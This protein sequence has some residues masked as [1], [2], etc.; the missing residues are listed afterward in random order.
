MQT[1]TTVQ[2]ATPAPKSTNPK[3]AV[4]ETLLF[5]GIMLVLTILGGLGLLW[6]RRR[7]LGGARDGQQGSLMDE[8]R[9]MRD[10]GEIS[11]E[12]FEATKRVMVARLSGRAGPAAGTRTT[13]RLQGPDNSGARPP[14]GSN[15]T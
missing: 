5:I 15:P 6:Y 4:G 12:E 14:D 7:V 3:Q 10:S 13:G 11:Q 9:R 1:G 2:P 8:F